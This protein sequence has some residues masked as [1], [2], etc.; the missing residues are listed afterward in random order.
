[1]YQ[2]HF[3]LIYFFYGLAFF[4]MGMAIVMELSHCTDERLRHAF[5]PLATFGIIHGLHEWIE[6]WKFQNLLPGQF[7]FGLLWDIILLG[8]LAFSFL[9]LAAFGVFLLAKGEQAQRFSLIAPILLI[10]I[11]GGGLLVL[12]SRYPLL[13]DLHYVAN[14]WTRYVLGIPAALLASAGLIFQ[15]REFRRAGMARFG[16]DSLWAAIAFLWYGLGGQTFPPESPIPPSNVIN[17]DLFLELFGFP[18]QLLRAV[19]AGV[20]AIFIIRVLR[21]FEEETR[22]KIAGLQA[23]RLD[24]AQRRE[25]LRGEMLRQ[26]VSAQEA[27][28]QRIAR[29]LHDETGQ[30]LTALGLGLRAIAASLPGENDRLGKNVAQLERLTEHALI[31]LQRL[32]A[33]LR[34]S[35]LDDLGL[36][37]ALRWYAGEIQKRVPLKVDVSITGERSVLSSEVKTTLFRIIQ[38]ALTN[39]IKHAEA[40][41]ARVEL[42]YTPAGVRVQ[43]S[44][45]GL[46]FDL[47]KIAASQRTSWGLIGMQERASLLGGQF[48]IASALG[49]GTR[50]E[51]FIPLPDG[52]NG[53][54]DDHPDDAG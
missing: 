46:G 4:S 25:A 29:E 47:H 16:R 44:D 27:E 40:E 28:R 51:V 22:R 30:A 12:M 21:S 14:V 18:V 26:V 24:E 20:A 5:R 7:R 54:E 17:Q 23:A 13:S 3:A 31:E 38:E 49:E 1:M 9:S 10:A 19:A 42:R 45:D 39:V 52:K 8:F 36:D 37:A 6:M 43:V 53:A 2:A 11:W 48:Q 34:P 15:Q 50:V 32:I 33:D 35:H 41:S